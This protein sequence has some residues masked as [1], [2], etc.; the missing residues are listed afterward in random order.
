M[1]KNVAVAKFKQPVWLY[2]NCSSN[3]LRRSV[4]SKTVRVLVFSYSVLLADNYSWHSKTNRAVWGATFGRLCWKS[5]FSQNTRILT[6][7][8]TSVA[9]CYV[10][11]ESWTYCQ[12]FRFQSQART[13]LAWNSKPTFSTESANSSQ[14]KVRLNEHCVSPPLESL[15]RLRIVMIRPIPR[16]RQVPG[17]SPIPSALWVCIGNVVSKSRNNCISGLVSSVVV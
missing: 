3:A 12:K 2:W 1:I 16:D 14:P 11:S 10:K 17:Y 5:R 4:Q 9:R 13:F 7:E 15:T 6:D 8:N